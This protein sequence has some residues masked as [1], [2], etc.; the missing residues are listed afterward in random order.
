MKSHILSLYFLFVTI[1][2]YAQLPDAKRDYQWLI[3]Y[4]DTV[5]EFK[6]VINLFDFNNKPLEI[7]PF[8]VKEGII[9]SRAYTNICDKN[10]QLL[11]YATGCNIVNTKG[12]IIENG[13]RT[14]PDDWLWDGGWCP[15]YYPFQRSLLF[16][17]D[18]AN[19]TL[20]YLL[21]F[22]YTPFSDWGII[23]NA[24]YASRMSVNK[25]YELNSLV[26]QDTIYDGHLTASRHANGRDWW[27]VL[28]KTNTNRYFIYLLDSTGFRLWRIQDIGVAASWTGTGS[29]QAV[30]SPDGT[31]YLRHCYDVDLLI[32]DFDRCTGELSNSIQVK[33]EHNDEIV[34]AQGL[35]ISPNSRFAYVT[36]GVYCYQVDLQASDLQTSVTEVA[37]WD[38][39]IIDTFWATLFDEAALAPDDKIYIACPGGN[40]TMS[41]RHGAL[42]E[43]RS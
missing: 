19:D 18:P 26:C 33:I 6:T 41:I 15:D 7:E 22:G 30:F 38:S 37:V 17:T 35:A 29:G 13:Q 9:Q 24:M 42:R 34:L 4:A 28:N 21:S 16:L 25:V 32:F 2:F 3:G 43:S 1:P 14:M 10:G 11:L 12:E 36:T 31:K 40:P 23:V 5:P 8:S 20:Y 39:T 27:V